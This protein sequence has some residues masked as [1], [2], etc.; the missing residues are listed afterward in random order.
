MTLDERVARLEAQREAEMRDTDEIKEKLN[1]LD[2][3]VN[4][5][6]SKLDKQKGFIA[7]ALMVL[8]G[9]WGIIV[10]VGYAGW[11]YVS[12]RWDLP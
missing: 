8:T 11:Q 9:L 12:S 2:D 5:I 3:K 1:E 7:G 4:T 10:A 6:N